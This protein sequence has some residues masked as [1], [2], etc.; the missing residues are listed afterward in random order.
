MPRR[1]R[2]HALHPFFGIGMI[3]GCVHCFFEFWLH[4]S[5]DVSREALWM[6]PSSVLA[7]LGKRTYRVDWMEDCIL[8]CVLYCVC[9]RCGGGDVCVRRRRSGLTCLS[10]G[11][12]GIGWVSEWWWW[13]SA[14]VMEL[15]SPVENRKARPR[16]GKD[17]IDWDT[18]QWG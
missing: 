17:G 3:A 14:H 11:M 15:H 10:G 4:Q 6:F 2:K 9:L 12:D 1:K 13:Y 5:S 18:M 7:G 16:E 8:C